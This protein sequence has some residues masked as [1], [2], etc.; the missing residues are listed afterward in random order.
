[1]LEIIQKALDDGQIACG[2]FIDLEKAFNTVSHDILLEK[3]DHYG[4]RSISNGWF[5][6]Y[7]TDR[8]Q[9]VSINGFNSD[10]KT[11]N[12]SVPQSFVLGS[13]L[14]LMYINDLKTAIKHCEIFHFAD[15][16]CL[17][18]IKDSVKQINKV[19]KLDLKFLVQWLNDNR[20]SLNEAKTEV[21]IFRR[22]K[23]H[24]DCDLNLKLCG[25]K[26]KP[27]NYVRYLGMY[28]DEYLNWSPDISH[29]N[30][31]FVKANAMLCKL[32]YFVNVATIK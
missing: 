9:F 8:S 22:E 19:F 21:A 15:D 6:S 26:L 4:I 3:L 1:M 30:Q 5:R 14:F 16:T 28:F 27:S 12:Y 18:N 17:L 20:I 29:L 13:L 31:K 10:F 25:K 11:I 7:L 2:I 24:L 23:K 32:R